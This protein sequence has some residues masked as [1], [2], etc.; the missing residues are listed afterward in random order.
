VNNETCSFQPDIAHSAK[1]FTTS[2][3]TVITELLT[4]TRM[5][6]AVLLCSLNLFALSTD[7]C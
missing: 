5:C 7:I 3:S 4:S 6:V 2:G 1:K